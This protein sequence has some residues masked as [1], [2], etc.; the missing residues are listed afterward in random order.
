[1]SGKYR[2]DELNIIR[3]KWDLYWSAK[4]FVSGDRVQEGAIGRAKQKKNLAHNPEIQEC[5]QRRKKRYDVIKQRPKTQ[6][7]RFLSM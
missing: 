6:K 4:E 7:R 3:F 2:L 5:H 1:M